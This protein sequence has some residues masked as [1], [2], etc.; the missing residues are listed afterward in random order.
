MKHYEVIID[1]ITITDKN[2]I[3]R[4]QA[5]SLVKLSFVKFQKEKTPYFDVKELK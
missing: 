2:S 4:I 1:Q 5:I 3:D